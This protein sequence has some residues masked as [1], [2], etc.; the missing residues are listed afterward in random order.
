[1]AKNDQSRCEPVLELSLSFEATCDLYIALCESDPGKWSD[2][3]KTFV[4]YLYATLKN[5]DA[6]HA[7]AAMPVCGSA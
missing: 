5:W 6:V 4:S 3:F 1:M 7:L 2:E